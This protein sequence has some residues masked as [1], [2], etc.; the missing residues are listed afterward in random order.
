MNAAFA[1]WQ[2]R[3]YRQ[4]V[5]ALAQG[6]LGHGLLLVGPAHLGKK[7]VAEALAQRMLC[8]TPT[9][10]DFACGQCRS[11]RLFVAQL[12]GL[13]TT[14]AHGDLQRVGLEPNDKGDKLRSEISIDQVRKLGQW[15]SLSAQFGGI[16]V[17]VIEPADRLTHAAANALLK[18]L[19]EP[20]PSRF[21]LLVSSR[22]G[23]LPATVR[24]RCQ[25]LEFRLPTE[26]EARAWLRDQGLADAQAGDAL[27][28]ARGNPGLAAH[29]LRTG[30]LRLRGEVLKALE[31]LRE[32]RA[33]PIE[34][35]QSWLADGHAE[36]RLR[37]AAE[38]ALDAAVRNQGMDGSGPVG[39]TPPADFP[40]LSTWFDGI[41]RLRE[42]LGAPL[43]HD[44]VL[45]GLLLDW[46]RLYDAHG[47][48]ASGRRTG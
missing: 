6:R 25:R 28:A 40:K 3:V 16:K 9:S 30:G 18:T 11:C 32:G 42:Q 12:V 24:S 46:R 44:L 8:P 36:L 7:A 23:R 22:P 17:A 15:F 33:S 45:A 1:P 19:E 34:L 5:D 37:F 47:A 38:L 2:L 31:S 4:A 14:Q 35:A 13:L 48:R 20:A 39:L 26:G 21:L 43:R 41:N 10:E 29:W 27:Q